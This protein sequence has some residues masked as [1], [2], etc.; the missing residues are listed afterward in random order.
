MEE[1][2][3]A[4]TQAG[5]VCDGQIWRT[6]GDNARLLVRDNDGV[7]FYLLTAYGD[8]NQHWSAFTYD[9]GQVLT[10]LRMLALVAA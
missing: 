2:T 7:P 4:L 3:Q 6:A 1:I 8:R 5:W 10:M 9:A